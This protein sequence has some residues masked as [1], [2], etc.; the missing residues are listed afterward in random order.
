M[1]RRI[2]VRHGRRSPDTLSSARGG[3]GGERRNGG[4]PRAEEE[5]ATQ[6]EPEGPADE[7][8]TTGTYQRSWVSARGKEAGPRWERGGSS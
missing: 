6:Q 3:S 1:S 7:E 5:G 4:G 2:S 8:G